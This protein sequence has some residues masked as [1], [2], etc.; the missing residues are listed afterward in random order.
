[1]PN[2]TALVSA[3]CG[4]HLVGAAAASGRAHPARAAAARAQSTA[5]HSWPPSSTSAG[6]LLGVAAAACCCWLHG[7]GA[8][9]C[10]G[11]RCCGCAGGKCCTC[12]R[13]A[14][15]L[16]LPAPQDGAASCPTA[17]TA[18]CCSAIRSGVAR[19]T[20]TQTCHTNRARAQRHSQRCHTH[21]HHTTQ[22]CPLVHQ[23]SR[24][25]AAGQQAAA[26]H[27]ALSRPPARPMSTSCSGLVAK[28]AECLRNSECMK[29]SA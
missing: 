22:A 1:M 11:R 28:Y 9:C 24:Q 4:A 5:W 12:T 15:P 10:W 14:R 17:Q 7:G 16:R 23:V 18:S 8:A 25:Q 6:W 21:T 27:A 26:G 3:L 19:F 29:A 2:T 20:A 13:Q